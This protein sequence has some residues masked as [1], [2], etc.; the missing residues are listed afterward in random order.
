MTFSLTSKLFRVSLVSGVLMTALL[1]GGC[2]KNTAT[3]D[4]ATTTDSTGV[5]TDAT[6]GTT[7]DSDSATTTPV[8]QPA[9]PQYSTLAH[10]SSD[11]F[12]NM[13]F[14]PLINS[15]SLTP[16]QKSCLEARDPNIGLAES[17]AFFES[18]FTEAELNELNEFY[19]SPVGMKLIEY[20]N[21]QLRVMNGLEVEK[22]MGEPTAEESAEMQ[23]FMQ[24]PVGQKYM[25]MN[26]AEGEGSMLEALRPTITGE[27]SR[28]NIEGVL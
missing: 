9:E 16:E 8:A 3:D 1:T 22:P 7:S 20:G 26:N 25:A 13:L 12:N 6:V 21:E 4:Q 10:L 11:T 2:N 18:K 23:K 28:C 27:L 17:Q 15:G 24:S 5:D 19:E 14:V